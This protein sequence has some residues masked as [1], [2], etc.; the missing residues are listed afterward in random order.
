MVSSPAGLDFIASWGEE[1]EKGIHRGSIVPISIPIPIEGIKNGVF[2]RFPFGSLP[3]PLYPLWDVIEG[4]G[5]SQAGCTRLSGTIFDHPMKSPETLGSSVSCS[6]RSLCS[7]FLVAIH[8]R[9]RSRPPLATWRVCPPCFEFE[10][11][12]PSHQ[13][14]LTERHPGGGGGAVERTGL[15]NRRGLRVTVGSNPTLTVSAHGPRPGD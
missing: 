1:K 2:H 10:Q 9:S 5:T 8:R 7:L 12:V 15:E 13:S 3:G 11:S 4:S 14:P 6:L